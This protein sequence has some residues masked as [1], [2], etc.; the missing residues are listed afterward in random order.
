MRSNKGDKILVGLSGGVDSAVA[1]YLLRQ[2]GY[3]VSAVFL[4]CFSEPKNIKQE[5]PWRED[6]LEAY[7]VAS[8]LKIPIATWDLQREYS[9]RVLE[10]TFA[11]YQKGRTPNPDIMCNKEIKFKVFLDRARLRGFSKI[12]TG[13]YAGIARDSEG[14]AHLVKARDASKDQTY[15]LAALSQ[16]QLRQTLFPLARLTKVRVRAL[17][18]SLGLPNSERPDSQGLCFIGQVKMRDF[19]QQRIRPKRGLVVNIEGQAVG[20]HPGVYY[21]TV[22][23]RRGINVGGGPALYVIDK[24]IKRNRLIVGSKNQSSLFRSKVPVSKWHWLARHRDFPFRASAKI[25]YRQSDQ[26]V[27]LVKGK[28]GKIIAIFDRPQRAVS[29]GQTLAV[30]VGRELAASGVID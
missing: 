7:R 29:A 2:D 24:D 22:G 27:R 6:R 11:E 15:F 30:Y 3:D 13:H 16:S 12:A 19:L 14:W 1:A 8:Y 23:Q 20:E 17:A 28:R 10:Y 4:K 5:C 26:A 21:F 18:R 9:Q 25:R